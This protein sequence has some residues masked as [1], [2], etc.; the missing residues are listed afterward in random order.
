MDPTTLLSGLSF[1]WSPVVAA[2]LIVVAVFFI[3]M[4]LAP[5]KKNTS[6]LAEYN[7][8]TEAIENADLEKS[9]FQRVV[10]PLLKKLLHFLGTLAPSKNIE[11][12]RMM[13]MAA[14]G[15]GGMSPLD[16]IG[17]RL[18]ALTIFAAGA[19]L[20]FSPTGLGFWPLVRN[21]LIAAVVGYFLPLLWLR[22]KVSA[23]KQ[24]ILK[25]LP[26]ALDML[27]IGVEAGLAFESALLRV[28]ERWNNA[29]TLEFRRTVGEMRM[30]MPRAAALQRMAER[31]GVHEVST[32]VAILVQ[33]DA[34]GVSIA[35]VLH[36]Q[37]F[38]MRVW[39][40]QRV[41]ELAQQAAVK[42]VFPLVFL[43]FPSMFIVILGPSLPLILSSFGN[44]A[45]G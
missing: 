17:L 40:R 35:E 12:V 42:M 26:D 25:A 30:G 18:L 36:A 39:R 1:L 32:F 27:T 11:S 19:F 22:S 2:V 31:T 6:R 10:W 24:Q 8:T 5:P 20:L 28:S 16:F 23:R 7:P 33:S 45:G 37:A 15:L 44:M 4:A 41:Q 34:L 9:F 38:Q 13:I 3:W 29:L 14:G 21:I 43:I